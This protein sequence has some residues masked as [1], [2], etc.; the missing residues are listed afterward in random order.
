MK[1]IIFTLIVILIIAGGIIYLSRETADLNRKIEWGVTFSQFFADKMKLD[2]Q[3][4][5][6][7][8]LN[9]LGVKNLRLVAYWPL[10]EPAK[11]Q[12]SFADLDWQIEQARQHNARVILAIGQKL[13]RWPECHIPDWVDSVDA[14]IRQQE[15]L[16][17]IETTI[18]HYKNEPTIIAWQIE[19][20]P[21]LRFGECPPFDADF[22]D[23]E[24][25]LTKKLDGRPIIIS[26]SGELSIWVS[27]A[28]RADIFGTT[29][30]RKVWNK[31]IGSLTYPLPPGFFRAKER[32]VRLFVG[33]QKPFMVIELQ[34]E[35]WSKKQIY[36]T[37][38]E[39]QL[40]SMSF[41]ELQEIINYAR[42]TGFSHYYLWGAEWWYSLRQNGH[43]EY[44]NYI[45]EIIE[46]NQK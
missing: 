2:W 12:Y 21:F 19:N 14:Q 15:L 38:L 4:S 30:Y 46:K 35:P 8:I 25:A 36:E 39:E 40:K 6:L 18:E 1:K 23:R 44:W 41:S 26:D 7:A 45:K 10:I 3:Q 43:P 20:E 28:R 24:I 27:A 34:A 29:M 17:Y 5:Y 22:L 32:I 13:P 33:Q 42:Q 31:W 37:T 9:D 16:K 11:D